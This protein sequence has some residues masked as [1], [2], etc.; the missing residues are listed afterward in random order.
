[1]QP[2]WCLRKERREEEKTSGALRK[3]PISSAVFCSEG[4][5]PEEDLV[6]VTLSVKP[7]IHHKSQGQQRLTSAASS[8]I[9]QNDQ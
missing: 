7:G 2:L 5:G 9:Q 1:M 3:C 8:N 4:V 6:S